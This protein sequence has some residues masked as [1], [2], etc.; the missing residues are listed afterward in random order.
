MYTYLDNN[1]IISNPSIIN[2]PKIN[3]ENYNEDEIITNS[4]NNPNELLTATSGLLTCKYDKG[5]K[6]AFTNTYNYRMLLTQKINDNMIKVAYN[7]SKITIIAKIEKW[8]DNA[9]DWSGIHLF[10]RYQT[11][12]DLYVASYR[13]DGMITLKKKINGKYYTLCSN[14]YNPIKLNTEYL[15]SFE[16]KDNQL[17]YYINNNKVLYCND[18]ELQY[19]VCGIRCDYCDLY[20]DN[21]RI[22]EP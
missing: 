9:P 20:L 8:H 5:I 7:N 21:I 1:Y 12:D 11:E 3:F 2:F 10:S 15:L 18:D 13:I 4:K 16:V 22:L 17:I 6:Y 14:L 19:G